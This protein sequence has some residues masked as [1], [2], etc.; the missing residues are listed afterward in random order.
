MSAPTD[1]ALLFDAP[2]PRG[3]RRIIVWSVISTLVILGVI[4]AG[5]TV[6]AQHGQLDADRW[7]PFTSVGYINFLWQGLEGTLAATAV[8]MV[9]AFPLALGLALLRVSRNRVAS[10]LAAGWI[11]FFRAIPM[12]LIVYAFLLFL[13]RQ[14]I[15][16]DL[17]LFWKLVIPMI[18]TSS[19]TTAETFRSGILA[20]DHGQREAGRSI[21]LTEGQSMRL[22]ILPQAIRLVVPSLINA[23]I[24][25]LKDST[26]G[27]VVSY[28]ELTQQGKVITTY[29]G[30][31]IQ[32]Y[33]VVAVIYVVINMILSRVANR[34]DRRMHRRAAAAGAA[35]AEGID[36]LEVNDAA[37]RLT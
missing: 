28:P 11:E 18:I 12:L 21:G 5:L 31:M 6:F 19:A 32:T 2:G 20:V 29:T 4:A 7:A 16:L 26:L 14:P 30:L 3:R 13:P 33:I 9:V 10:T 35:R 23:L 37:G 36:E 17:P 27:Y 24:S 25:L 15:G 8:A 34:L 1:A 22:V